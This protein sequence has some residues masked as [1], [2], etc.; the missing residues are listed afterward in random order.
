MIEIWPHIQQ[1]LQKR[2]TPG[3]F[4]V[5]ITPL[6]AEVS[7]KE[8]RLTAPND[9]VA[10]WVRDRLLDDI[11]AAAA[12]VM[13]LS[14]NDL[15]ATGEMPVVTVCASKTPQQAPA[16][17]LTQA[18]VLP[19]NQADHAEAAFG[20]K[21][22][23]D[24]RICDAGEV[25]NGFA[26][27]GERFGVAGGT[28]YSMTQQAGFAETRQMS[29][30]ISQP[31][32]S[33]VVDWRFDF[34]S[35]VVGPSNNLAFAA[36]QGITRSSQSADTLFLSSGPGLGKT[37]LMQA[38]GNE[39]CRSSNRSRVRV[40]YLTAEEF[41]TRLIAALKSREVDRFKARYR[42]VDLL[43]LEDVHFLQGK[44]RMQDEVLA[45]I[46]AL[47]SR[48]SRVVLSSS[49]A[50]RDLKELDSQLVSRFC[51]GFLAAIE[52]P[53]FATRRDILRRK[54]SQYQVTLPDNVT[55][56]LAENIR[57][58][59]RQIESCLH[60]LILKAR[61]LNQQIS[62]NIAWEVISQ[63]ASHETVMDMESIV[64]CV[65]NGFDLSPSQLNSRSRRRELVVARNTV[66]YLAR[67]HTDMSLKDI[68][69][70]FNRKHSTV[71][72]GITNLERE[73]SR[74][75]PIG[76]QVASTVALIERNGRVLYT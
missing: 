17:T 48:G 43:L 40:E 71:L 12:E 24:W 20:A 76:R 7:G 22:V 62:M 68:G 73:M 9:F 61:I 5:W 66:F 70:H 54:A 52:R 3:L 55:D 57:A 19:L 11:T 38:V 50:P 75:T 27:S 28:Q 13:S 21:T 67:K 53:D 18:G 63:Y 69:D 8:I 35:F 23:A 45:T 2:L 14:Q 49:F 25:A 36:S 39:L 59:V 44:E 4:K 60:N 29:L 41:G 6:A 26:A 47:Q 64:R 72:K 33:R 42:D 31:L 51:S 10:S 58:D 16:R 74:E 46:K 34:E 65:C 32:V 15:S 30:P 37:H 1:I 56:L